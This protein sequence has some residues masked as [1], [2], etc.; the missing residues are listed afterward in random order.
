VTVETVVQYVPV[1]QT[2]FG[3]VEGNCYA[4]CIAALTGIPLED[5]P[6][7]CTKDSWLE[8]STAWL[9]ERGWAL[10]FV[11]RDAPRGAD[12]LP[13]DQTVW[14][15]MPYI[16]SG[17][18]PRGDF[19]HACVYANGKLLHDPHPSNQ[20]VYLPIIDYVFVFPMTAVRFQ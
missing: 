15:N 12:D 20:G 10:A 4:S 2:L 8:D 16:V 1:K 9:K 3:G 5:I 18:S 6:N 19:L 7:F 14:S 11:Y 13:E 17:Q